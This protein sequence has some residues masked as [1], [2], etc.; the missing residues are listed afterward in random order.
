MAWQPTDNLVDSREQEIVFGACFIEASKIY[1]H[2]P[3]DTFILDHDYDGEPC[4]VV[5]WF[6]KLSFEQSMDFGLG[7]FGLLV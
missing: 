2:S 4:G 5:I 3:L 7:C 1:A 6:D